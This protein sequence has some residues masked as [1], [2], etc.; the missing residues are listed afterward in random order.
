VPGWDG[1]GTAPRLEGVRNLDN[2]GAVVTGVLSWRGT[3]GI[4][5]WRA[6]MGTR[7]SAGGTGFPSGRAWQGSPRL[8]DRGGDQ[9]PGRR[10]A[11]G[12]GHRLEGCGEGDGF[13]EGRESQAEEARGGDEGQ[14][15][16]VGQG[17]RVEDPREGTGSQWTAEA[18]RGRLAARPEVTRRREAGAADPTADG[19][20]GRAAPTCPRWR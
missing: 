5:G 4:L 18:R 17:W 8:E 2:R 6:R 12:R 7:V 9:I 11:V 1:G 3:V 10:D 14:A 13:K 15:G 20:R 19:R 16:E